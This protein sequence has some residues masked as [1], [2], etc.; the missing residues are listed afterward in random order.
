MKSWESVLLDKNL[1]NPIPPPPYVDL[2]EKFGFINREKE[3]EELLEF[4]NKAIIENSGFLIFILGDQGKGKTTFLRN[5]KRKYSYPK[6]NILYVYMKFPIDL[7]ELNFSYIYKN[8]LKELFYSKILNEIQDKIFKECNY[9]FL[10]KPETEE[11]LNILLNKL[12]KEVGNLPP[13][14]RSYPKIISFVISST[15]PSP[16]EIYYENFFYNDQEVP[17][18][19]PS[20]DLVNSKNEMDA[21]TKLGNFSKFLKNYLEITHT[22]LMIDDFDIYER[23]EKIYRSLYKILMGFRNDSTLLKNFTL[24]FAGS[25]TFYDEF[26]QSLSQNE[27]KRIEDW[28]YPIYFENLNP[29]NFVDLIKSA[30]NK[31]WKD[32]IQEGA[33]PPDNILGIFNKDTLKFLYDYNR[34][35]LRDTLRNIFD[36]IEKIRKN[37]KITYYYDIKNFI[38]EFKKDK[39]NLN[40]LECEFFRN[41]LEKRVKQEKSSQFINEKLS[42]IFNYLKKYFESNKIFIEADSE[43]KILN[44]S[45]DILLKVMKY[46]EPPYEVIFE[47]KM[48]EGRVGYDDIKSRIEILKEN[49]NRYLYWITKSPLEDVSIDMFISYRILRKDELNNTELAYLSYL[50]NL[51]E[52]FD[53]SEFNF[54]DLKTLLKQSGIDFDLILNPKIKPQ[55]QLKNIEKEIEN[56]L[57]ENAQSKVFIKKETVYKNLKNK[58]FSDYSQQYIFSL[59]NDIS[60][61]LNFKP[62]QETVQF[63]KKQI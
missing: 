13:I 39:V 22:V 18:E 23:N 43:V 37:G 46:Y 58:G 47:I 48:K 3:E 53:L 50:I 31:F 32:Y 35:D 8:Y 24:I 29:D 11:E 51:S 4:V 30:F 34:R 28:F 57:L 7:E 26:I 60:K 44:Y 2:D 49:Q 41:E 62:T 63:K 42:Q 20:S 52:I 27:R 15:S 16:T 5:F 25:S 1:P 17:N 61:K 45:A 14:L 10:K 54:E 55:I 21:I 36:L 33:L 59:I 56:I 19:I 9:I 40:E 38:K 6:S 12:K